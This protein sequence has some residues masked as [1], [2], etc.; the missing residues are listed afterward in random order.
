VFC[1][2]DAT[3][4]RCFP[5]H[6]DRVING[7]QYASGTTCDGIGPNNEELRVFSGEKNLETVT[8][9]EG[10]SKRV[11]IICRDIAMHQILVVAVGQPNALN[12]VGWAR[13]GRGCADIK[14]SRK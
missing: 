2:L 1:V 8:A 12:A 5:F 7:F 14:Y 3:S 10:A 9:A 6:E 13:S 4:V 11:S